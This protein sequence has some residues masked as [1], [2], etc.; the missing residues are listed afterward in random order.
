MTNKKKKTTTTPQSIF[1]L[2]LKKMFTPD[3]SVCLQDVFTQREI[4]SRTRRTSRFQ[5]LG[6]ICV[7]VQRFRSYSWGVV[8]Q[9]IWRRETHPTTSFHTSRLHQR[10]RDFNTFHP[11]A[12][13]NLTRWHS[14]L[15]SRGDEE[16]QTPEGEAGAQAPSLSAPGVFFQDIFL[17]AELLR[18]ERGRAKRYWLREESLENC[19]LFINA[20]R[21]T[22]LAEK[23]RANKDRTLFSKHGANV[24]GEKTKK[25]KTYR[26]NPLMQRALDFR[27]HSLMKQNDE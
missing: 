13:V 1:N 20:H 11:I 25:Q 16:P 19:S 15:F 7:R 2:W 18:S 6:F 10:S 17:A 24:A 4:N 3:C 9:N 26:F 21:K 23:R 12:G 22:C 27:F 8:R 14:P 5:V